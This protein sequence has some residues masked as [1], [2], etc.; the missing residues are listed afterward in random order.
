MQLQEDHEHQQQNGQ[1]SQ[2]QLTKFRFTGL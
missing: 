2:E 1:E